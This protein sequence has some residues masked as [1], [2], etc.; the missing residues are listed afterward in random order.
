MIEIQDLR[1]LESVAEH[2]SFSKAAAD[3]GYT[4][5]AISYRIARLERELDMIP[6]IDRTP[7]GR[8]QLTAAGHVA[9]RYAHRITGDLLG[10]QRE[11]QATA[12]SIR[13]VAFPTA[14]ATLVPRAVAAFRHDHPGV[15]L[16]LA[17]AEP[18]VGMPMLARGEVDLAIGYTYPAVGQPG[19][20]DHAAGG[21]VQRPDGAGATGRPPARRAA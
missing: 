3:L 10:L 20:H 19:D 17:E 14:A 4:Q 11:V 5:P 18:Q 21:A 1:I 2:G 9:L 12:G 15:R 6:L 8:V 7:R 16:H 13:V